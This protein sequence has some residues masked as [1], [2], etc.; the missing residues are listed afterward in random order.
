M[1]RP[2]LLFAF[3][4]TFPFDASAGP[5]EEAE[6]SVQKFVTSFNAANNLDELVGMFSPD[7][8]FWGTISPEL[9][10]TPDD[11]RKYFSAN[12]AARATAP[13]VASVGAHSVIPLSDDIVLIAGRWQ[14]E[15]GGKT[16]DLRFSSVLNKRNGHWLI[17][18]FHSS[19]SPTP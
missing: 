4:L 16:I 8:Q 14:V 2:V 6:A 18:Q 5:K 7:A 1:I 11:V 15:R 17:T 10:V 9:A 19:L 12:F 13:Q 3:C